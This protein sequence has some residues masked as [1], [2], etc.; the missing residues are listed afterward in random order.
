[1]PE[2]INTSTQQVTIRTRRGNLRVGPKGKIDGLQQIIKR[3]LRTNE[4]VR[5]LAGGIT[6]HTLLRWRRRDTDPFPP[7]WLTLKLP[8]GPL[9]L[10]SRTMVEDWLTARRGKRT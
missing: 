5:E 1:M 4:Q 9:E 8:G 2:V 10:W 6:R 3:E 7:P